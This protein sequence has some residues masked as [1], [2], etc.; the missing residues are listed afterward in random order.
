MPH[1]NPD[2]HYIDLDNQP[3]VGILNDFE[4]CSITIP[5]HNQ[6]ILIK[7]DQG[8]TADVELIQNSFALHIVAF[9]LLKI[10]FYD[11]AA[12]LIG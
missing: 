4:E 7:I 10:F 9:R 12:L 3:Y 2:E 1:Q 5:L 11:V 8:R 6:H